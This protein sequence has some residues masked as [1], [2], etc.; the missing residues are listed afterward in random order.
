MI[1]YLIKLQKKQNAE[2]KKINAEAQ[3]YHAHTKQLINELA[4]VKEDAESSTATIGARLGL[5]AVDQISTSHPY[6]SHPLLYLPTHQK[7]YQ[8]F[9]LH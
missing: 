7:R 6:T 2:T 5:H 8:R 3:K 9:D 1:V 4:K